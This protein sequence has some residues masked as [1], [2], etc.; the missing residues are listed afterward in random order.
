MTHTATEETPTL[1]DLQQ[2]RTSDCQCQAAVKTVGF[3][4]PLFRYERHGFFV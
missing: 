2:A 4:A 3:P 1:E